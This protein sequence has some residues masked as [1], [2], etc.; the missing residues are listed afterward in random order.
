MLI[1]P[2]DP[3]KYHGSTIDSS[4]NQFVDFRMSD[5]ERDFGQYTVPFL[6]VQEVLTNP[7]IPLSGA[8]IYHKGHEYSGGFLGFKVMHYDYTN[9]L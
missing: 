5:L 3:T 4:D 2:D 1:E 7:P 9:H 8:G 6:D